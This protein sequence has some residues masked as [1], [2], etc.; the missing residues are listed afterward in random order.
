MCVSKKSS[1]HCPAPTHSFAGVLVGCWK[2]DALRLTLL[3]LILFTY[4]LKIHTLDS[5]DHIY[6]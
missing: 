3:E 1:P 4:S 2:M 5:V 6:N